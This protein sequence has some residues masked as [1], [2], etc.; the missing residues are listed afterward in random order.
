MP[1]RAAADLVEWG[2]LATAEEQF[3]A[4]LNREVS[5]NRVVAADINAPAMQDDRPVN[6]YNL[7]RTTGDRLHWKWLQTG[8]EVV[9]FWLRRFF[10]EPKH[11]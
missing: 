4:I 6:E 2:P 5:V 8:P 10:E 11:S 3:A 9:A 7:L 1:P